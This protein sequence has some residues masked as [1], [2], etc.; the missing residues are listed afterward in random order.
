MR[1]TLTI[2]EDIAIDL[3]EYA[4]QHGLTFKEVVNLA[5]RQGLISAQGTQAHREIDPPTVSLGGMVPG[6]ALSYEDDPDDEIARFLRVT[7]ETLSEVTSIQ[8]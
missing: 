2:D 6:V 3:K 5:L 1:T 8:R 7:Q 4:H